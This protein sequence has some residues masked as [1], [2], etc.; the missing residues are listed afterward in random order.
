VDAEEKI[1]SKKIVVPPATKDDFK[2]GVQRRLLVTSGTAIRP[3][4]PKATTRYLYSSEE[5]NQT[6][7][8]SE[9]KL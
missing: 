9:V 1:I 7:L 6:N 5:K 8:L 2:K 4:L 3:Q